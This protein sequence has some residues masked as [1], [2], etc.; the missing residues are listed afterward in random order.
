[1]LASKPASLSVA[2]ASDEVVPTTSGTR[3]VAAV[4]F[5]VAVRRSW[6]GGSG[7]RLVVVAREE[8]GGGEACEHE[9]QQG[10][11]PGPDLRQ[12][13]RGGTVSR[14]LDDNVLALRAGR[15]SRPRRR[16]RPRT[17]PVV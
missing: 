5:V 7:G 6:G 12:P 3:T 8:V 9:H 11:E 4:V 1:M 2:V 16:S 13:R 17:V 15:A 10:E 14:L